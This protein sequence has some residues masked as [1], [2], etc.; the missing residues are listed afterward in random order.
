MQADTIVPLQVQGTQALDRYAYVNNNPLRYVDPGGDFAIAMPILIGV[1]VGVAVGYAGQVINNLS[2]DMSFKEALTTDISAGWIIGG[3][4]AGGVLGGAGFAALSH[5]G[6]IPAASV[7]TATGSSLCTDGDCTNEVQ[8]AKQVVEEG[9]EKTSQ[10]FQTGTNTVYRLVENGITKY[11]GITNNFGRR[12]LEHLSTHNWRVEPIDGLEQLSRFDARA[13]EQV[14]IEHFGLPNLYN[15]INCI[16][17]SNSIYSTAVQR[18][19]DILNALHM[20]K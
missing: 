19:R 17:N 13:V 7:T 16:S 6:I 10:S 14:L 5:F 11:V 15:Q 4:V 3:A 8:I 12:F 2:N 1:G 9:F 20:Q 18:G